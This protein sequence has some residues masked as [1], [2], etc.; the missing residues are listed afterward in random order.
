M[1][2]EGVHT[3]AHLLRNH[4]NTGSLSGTSKARNSEDF[5]KAGEHVAGLGKTGFCDESLFILELS[6][7]VVDVTGSLERRAS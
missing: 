3:T 5:S 2:T 7:D 6:M 1:A 4:D